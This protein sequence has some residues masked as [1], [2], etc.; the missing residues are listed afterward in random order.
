MTIAL[1]PALGERAGGRAT[2]HVDASTVSD[3]LHQ[4][5]ERFPDLKALVWGPDGDLSAFLAVFL[6][7]L[8]LR[9]AGGLGTVLRAGDELSLVTAVEGGA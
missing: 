5:T 1:A 4:L 2:V 8:D 9:E 6:Q 7:D 3:A